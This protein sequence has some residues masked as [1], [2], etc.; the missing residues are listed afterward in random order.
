VVIVRTAAERPA[1]T[2]SSLSGS[3][4]KFESEMVRPEDRVSASSGFPA[5]R[6]T[7]EPRDH[8]SGGLLAENVHDEAAEVEQGPFGGALAL[9]VFRRAAEM[10]VELLL[11]FR[12][13]GLHLWS[14]EAGANDEEFR[15]SGSAAQVEYGN[16][17]GF[18]SLRLDGEAD[19]LWARIRVSPI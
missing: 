1:E 12:A 19:T 13:D 5:G 9:A 8:N 18:F 10:L 11:D 7:P 17:G 2:A 4:L 3:W 15:E 16:P 14:A 6:Q